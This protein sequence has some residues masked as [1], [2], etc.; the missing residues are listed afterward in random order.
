MSLIRQTVWL[1][2]DYERVDDKSVI[3]LST[4][5]LLPFE[6]DEVSPEMLVLAIQNMR[7]QEDWLVQHEVRCIQS[8]LQ[9]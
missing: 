7:E 9:S 5:E 2:C 1:T 8:L 4:A 3:V 6:E